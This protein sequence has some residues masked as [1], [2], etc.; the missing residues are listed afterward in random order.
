MGG[1][2]RCEMR[3][4]DGPGGRVDVKEELKLLLALHKIFGGWGSG[5]SGSANLN[6]NLRK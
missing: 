6:V 4:I 3:K 1:Q 2:S 5:P